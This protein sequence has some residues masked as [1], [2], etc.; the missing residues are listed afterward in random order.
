MMRLSKT[1]N[2]PG[3]S[4]G[5]RNE[6]SGS[7]TRVVIASASSPLDA[8]GS[9]ADRWSTSPRQYPG[10]L[11]LPPTR[12]RDEGHVGRRPPNAS[13]V[14]PASGYNQ[15]K[16]SERQDLAVTT[17]KH[18]QQQQ[19]RVDQVDEWQRAAALMTSSVVQRQQINGVI[20]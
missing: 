3:Y 1:D 2:M 5:K 6:A 7:V 11:T 12:P 4:S 14:L 13:A 17:W 16:V 9:P 15:R 8:A 19:R 20:L 18:Q 10:H